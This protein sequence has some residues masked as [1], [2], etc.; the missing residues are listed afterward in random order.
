MVTIDFGPRRIDEIDIDCPPVAY[1]QALEQE[2]RGRIAEHDIPLLPPAIR[3]QP[4][5]HDIAAFLV[6][7]DEGPRWYLQPLTIHRA[8]PEPPRR[9]IMRGREAKCLARYHIVDTHA[10]PVAVTCQ[11]DGD[12]DA[13]AEAVSRAFSDYMITRG[14]PVYCADMRVTFGRAWVT[15]P[16]LILPDRPDCAAPADHLDL[17]PE[18]VRPYAPFLSEFFSR[19]EPG[20][21]NPD[22][23]HAQCNLRSHITGQGYRFSAICPEDAPRYDELLELVNDALDRAGPLS[24]PGA[25]WEYDLQI[26]AEFDAA[27]GW[28]LP[29]GQMLV[30]H[31]FEISEEMYRR[32][33][34]VTCRASVIPDNHWR[35]RWYDVRCVT[36]VSPARI[37][38]VIAHADQSVRAMIESAVWLPLAEDGCFT[39]EFVFENFSAV[40]DR[41]VPGTDPDTLPDLCPVED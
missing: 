32:R 40:H 23:G 10:Q 29:A 11:S 41:G 15:E 34:S 13:F 18:P 14:L 12:A 20:T 33:A 1:R 3:Q 36:S 16:Q 7:S 27:T 38:G 28:R 6:D 31:P 24:R 22:E 39:A 17:Y 30:S 26:E 19:Y 21:Y 5:Q 37:P 9:Q 35:T 4:V 25:A 2:I 8:V